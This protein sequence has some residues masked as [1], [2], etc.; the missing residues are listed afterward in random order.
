MHS[1]HIIKPTNVS[2]SSFLNL[3]T[4]TRTVAWSTNSNEYAGK[5]IIYLNGTVKSLLVTV[6]ADSFA[7][8]LLATCAGSY[9][10]WTLIASSATN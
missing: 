1:F 2:N 9:D 3:D 10:S 8:Y 6:R 7:L 4:N 5:Y